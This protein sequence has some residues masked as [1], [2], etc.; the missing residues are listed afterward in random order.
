MAKA[1]KLNI[2]AYQR[3]RCHN[4]R[5]ILRILTYGVIR[6]HLLLVAV[7]DFFA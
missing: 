7:C 4:Y 5:R 6:G 2:I 1:N 3:E